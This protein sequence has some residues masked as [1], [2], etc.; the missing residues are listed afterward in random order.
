MPRNAVLDG[1]A[2]GGLRFASRLM[3]TAKSKILDRT[4][5]RAERAHL[6]ESGRRLVFT[7]GCFDLL[8]AG[9]VS[10]LAFAR[11]QGDVLVVGLN[12][13]DSMRRSK[14]PR[15]P[16]VPEAERALVL[17]SMEARTRARSASGTSGRR[18][19][20][21]RRMESSE[22]SPTTRTSPCSRANA[23]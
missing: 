23:R 4:A 19:P 13:D 16:L 12:S 5:M 3:R 20:L 22:F 17:A 2:G 11:E 14:G 9:H 15:R 7:N 18:G 1:G 21:L 8:H 10:Y 6:R